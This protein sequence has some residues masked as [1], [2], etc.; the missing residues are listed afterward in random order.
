[1]DNLHIDDHIQI[2][3]RPRRTSDNI[4][5]S[6]GKINAYLDGNLSI[7]NANEFERILSSSPEAMEKLNQ[8]MAEREIVK[9]L[10]PKITLTKYKKEG[11]V[12]ELDSLIDTMII[13]EET[14]K[15]R[16]T[17]SIKKIIQI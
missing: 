15:Q 17:N 1:M 14:L 6:S 13:R 4:Y 12:E 10:I 5:I 8:L 11:I 9:N 16:I 7:N 3:Q 2:N